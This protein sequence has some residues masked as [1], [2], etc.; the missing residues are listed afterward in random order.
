MFGLRCDGKKVKNLAIIDKAE[1][2]FMPMRC[3]ATNFITIDIPCSPMD[4]FIA[5][6]RRNGTTFSYMHIVIATIVRLIHLRP[7]LNRFIMRGSIYQR[8]ELTVSMDIKKKLDDDGEQATLKFYFTGRESIYE[9]KKIIDDMIAEES[10]EKAET[11]TTKFIKGFT[12]LPDW[13]F[14]WALAIFRWMDRHG[15]LT[16]GMVK[17]SPF[18]TSAFVTNLKSLKIPYIYHHLYNFG[19]TSM[20]FSLGKEKMMPVVE[21]NKDIK[22]AKMLQIGFSEDERIA[23]GYYM[24]KTLKLLKEILGN[25]DCL[26]EALPDEY[27]MPTSFKKKKKAKKVGK[28]KKRRLKKKN[29]ELLVAENNDLTNV[30]T[31]ESIQEE[32]KE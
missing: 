18:H 27:K 22:V 15:L 8:N 13:M 23:D 19:T 1:P 21:N 25:P 26:K 32:I 12:K 30:E 9:V 16:K 3:D 28:V 29:K 5:R 14:R 10:K 17:A 2:F 31:T 4:D 24:A 20:F 11:K 6:E 7:R